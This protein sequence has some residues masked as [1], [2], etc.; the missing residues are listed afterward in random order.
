VYALQA[1]TGVLGCT[2]LLIS[3]LRERTHVENALVDG[4]IE[5]SDKLIGSRA[6]RELTVH[7]FRGSDYLRGRHEVEITNE[8]MVIH[9]RTEVQFSD[10]PER[11]SEQRIRMGFGIERLDEMLGGGLL[12]GST[13]ALLGAPGTGKTLM[14]MRE[15]RYDTAVREFR[16]TDK[17]IDV[18]GSFESAEA[19]LSGLGRLRQG[20]G[21]GT[22]GKRQ[23]RKETTRRTASKRTG[24]SGKGGGRGR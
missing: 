10:P 2:T 6:V 15:S 22:R 8:G 5:L 21:K 14:K 4:I 11:A 19:M 3:N 24:K 12:S 7:K 9:P 1:F 18:A 17:G 20:D 13:T 16:I 23:A